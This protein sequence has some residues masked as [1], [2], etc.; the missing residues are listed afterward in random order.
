MKKRLFIPLALLLVSFAKVPSEDHS[1]SDFDEAEIFIFDKPLDGSRNFE[2][3][4]K[5]FPLPEREPNEIAH[6]EMKDNW[7]QKDGIVKFDP[8]FSVSWP[9]KKQEGSS[10]SYEQKI[11]KE[12]GEIRTKFG[13][14][15]E[16]GR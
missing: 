12:G 10:F 14:S 2:S 8:D 6:F 13:F 4:L 5:S 7:K 3:T 11:E 15:F 16:W 1:P 9:L